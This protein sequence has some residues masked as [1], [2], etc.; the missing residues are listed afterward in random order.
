[1]K[2]LATVLVAVLALASFGPRPSTAENQHQ[3]THSAE[4]VPVR[5]TIGPFRPFSAAVWA[6]DHWRRGKPPERT[7]QAE[8]R[9]LRCAP[10]GHRR[11]MQ[12]T[13]RKDERAFYEHRH[14]KR[15]QMRRLRYLPEACGGGVRSAI[16]C[17]IMWCESGGSYTADNPTSTAY[18][19]YQMLASTYAAYCRACDWSPADQDYAAY[20]LYR[21]A[22][23]R[24][25][26]CA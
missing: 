10:P 7:I 21:A 19:K 16:P 12:R 25:W 14:A 1:M 20:T 5:C 3:S 9:R 8:R 11:A 17:S 13:W 4:L 22:G 2:R 26:A 18:G 6:F 23:S 15:V 24:P